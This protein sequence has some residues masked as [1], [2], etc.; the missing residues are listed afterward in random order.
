[1]KNKILYIILL[2]PISILWAEKLGT[3]PEINKPEMIEIFNNRIYLVEGAT[4]YVYDLKDLRLVKKFGKAGEGPGE[5]K[6]N[7]SLTNYLIPAP[8]YL[9]MVGMDKAIQYT[10]EGSIIKEFRI[11]QFTNFLHPAGDNYVAMKFKPQ[12]Q[13]AFLTTMIFSSTFKEIKEIYS[14]PFSG[15]RN[16]LN[17]TYDGLNIG[18]FQNKIFMEQSPEGFVIGVY[19]TDGKLLYKIDKKYKKL[20][21]S[22]KHKEEALNRIK[23][24]PQVKGIGWN[25]LKKVI[26]ITHSEYLPAIQDILIA[27]KLL[28]IKTSLENEGKAEFIVMDFAGNELKRTFLPELKTTQI[29]NILFARPARLFKIYQGKYYYLIEN[30]DDEEWEL[31][32][33]NI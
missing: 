8:E 14:Q 26:K 23:N 7:R 17:L 20:K 15:G 30:E 21:F 12:G 22:A 33:T 5:L 28:Y 27:D 11:P 29:V 25:N 18:V 16:L 4:A 19:N 10:Y 32:F 2:F 13:K 24:D 3:L 31:H 6:V 9:L 1:M